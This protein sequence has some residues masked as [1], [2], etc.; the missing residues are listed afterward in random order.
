MTTTEDRIN[1]LKEVWA[2]AEE[3]KN[4]DSIEAAIYYL[5]K[6]TMKDVS[7]IKDRQD[8]HEGILITIMRYVGVPEE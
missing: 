2:T 6:N 7:Y 8:L 5:L 1:Q 3:I 4:N